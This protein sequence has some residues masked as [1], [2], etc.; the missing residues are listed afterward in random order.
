[1]H[2]PPLRPDGF[3]ADLDPEG[4]SPI[5]PQGDPSMPDSTILGGLAGTPSP[6]GGAAASPWC[7]APEAYD[8]FEF[9][10]KCH[11]DSAMLDMFHGRARE[12]NLS[13]QAAQTLVDM[14]LQS[15]ESFCRLQHDATRR[16]Q[17]F[18]I[19]AVRRDPE[20]GGHRLQENLSYAAETIRRLGTPG[21]QAAL[22]ESGLGNHPEIV[23]F[24]VRVGQA[25]GEG[26]YVPGG[27][28]TPRSAA[29]ILYPNM[30]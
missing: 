23:R 24:F 1:M 25:I 8:P 2:T 3:R 15:L 9:P 29:E 21:L 19:E 14:H 4:V 18:W 10:S 28:R 13:Q 27:Y 26:R 11:V 16:Q 7:G 17:E 20:I 30:R 6:P 12:M 22:N 5:G